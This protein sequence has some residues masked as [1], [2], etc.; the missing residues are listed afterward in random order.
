MHKAEAMKLLVTVMTIACLAGCSERTPQAGVHH[1]KE[2]ASVEPRAETKDD[3]LTE[4]FDEFYAKATNG[5]AV[6]QNLLGLALMDKGDPDARVWIEKAASQGLT[7]AHCDLGYMYENGITV[8]VDLTAAAKHYGIAADAGYVLAQTQLGLMYAKGHGVPKDYKKALDLLSPASDQ[9]DSLAQCALGV[10]YRKGSGVQKSMETACRYFGLA[11]AQG[12]ANAQYEIGVSYAT[13]DGVKKDM[14]QALKW[15]SLAAANGMPY[16]GQ[17]IPQMKREMSQ[18][19]IAAATRMAAE[20][21]PE[22]TAQQPPP[23]DK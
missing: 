17:A 9:G 16:A 23:R 3:V 7:Q 15:T 6:A 19:Q 20:F 18:A 14:V 2:G 22:Q 12:D 8:P 21:K 4:R 5:D 1:Q 13:G 11:A 10:M